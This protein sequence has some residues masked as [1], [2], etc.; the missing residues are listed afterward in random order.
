MGAVIVVVLAVDAMGVA[1]SA[2]VWGHR[3]TA[4][5]NTS[6]DRV[7]RLR[8]P[9][10]VTFQSYSIAEKRRLASRGISFRVVAHVQCSRPWV[11]SVNGV[12]ARPA[13]LPALPTVTICPRA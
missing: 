13:T 3:N 10:T 5:E 2:F 8:G 1:R 7:R 12:L 4:R 11:L 6:L 9:L